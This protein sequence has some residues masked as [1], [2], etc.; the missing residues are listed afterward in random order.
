MLR[1]WH[2]LYVESKLMNAKVEVNSWKMDAGSEAGMT[3]R[4]VVLNCFK[5][6]SIFLVL[7]SI[8][9]EQVVI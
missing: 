1:G 7:I 6:L 2:C 3:L 4:L 9:N 5:E 8:Y